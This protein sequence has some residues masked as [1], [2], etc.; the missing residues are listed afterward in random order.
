MT[1]HI[2][3]L[4]KCLVTTVGEIVLKGGIGL[5]MGRTEVDLLIPFGVS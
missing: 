2:Y 5:F 1:E 3:G 4:A